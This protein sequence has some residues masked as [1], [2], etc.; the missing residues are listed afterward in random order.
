MRA[1]GQMALTCHETWHRPWPEEGPFPPS[2]HA[3]DQAD[4]TAETVAVARGPEMWRL[5]CKRLLMEERQREW[6]ARC[7]SV[8]A[9]QEQ[10][11]LADPDKH[12]QLKQAQ[13]ERHKD[14]SQPSAH[15]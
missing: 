12:R 15:T 11:K 6:E 8:E 13:V 3:G 2:R 1:S 10:Q 4:D 7:Q 5:L 9:E 14:E